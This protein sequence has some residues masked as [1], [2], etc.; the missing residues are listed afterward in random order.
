MIDYSKLREHYTKSRIKEIARLFENRNPIYD[1]N[2]AIID[3][4][5]KKIE[6]QLKKLSLLGYNY[7]TKKLNYL[8]EKKKLSIGYL[9][10]HNFVTGG[11]KILIEQG[12]YLKDRGHEVTLYCHLPK[13]KWIDLR[14]EY[15]QVPSDKHLYRLVN[16]KD[17]VIAGYWDLIIDALKS[18]APIKYYFAQGDIFIFNHENIEPI[19]RNL[20][21]TSHKLPVK[22]ITVSNIMKGKINNLYKRKSII[23]PNAIDN[24][25]FFW[26]SKEDQETP[27]EILIVGNDQLGFKGHEDIINALTILKKRG[28]NFRMKWITPTLPVI[29]YRDKELNINYIVQPTQ[30]ELGRLYREA[31]IYISGSYY[32]SFSLPP[33]EAM[34]SGTM[35]ITTSNEG[36]K[37][38]AKDK[39]NCLMYSCGNVEELSNKIEGALGSK[40][41]RKMLISEGLKTANNFSWRSSI[42]KFENEILSYKDNIKVITVDKI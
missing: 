2:T 15:V 17:I 21:I 34:A 41:L 39:K 12:N 3:G 24:N 22:I 31:D 32:E 14:C 28:Y 25:M 1:L 29:D 8:K 40:E 10:P 9:L 16:N 4:D 26:K 11:L 5:R 33:L 20:I 30:D 42:D 13:P 7:S 23:I 18:S 35:V 19:Y 37:E 36:V 38:Y 6:I 27:I